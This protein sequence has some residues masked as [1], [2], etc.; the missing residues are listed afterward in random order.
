MN[1]IRDA[2]PKQAKTELAYG[3]RVMCSHVRVKYDQFAKLETG[4]AQATEAGHPQWL[5]NIY[6]LMA[7]W[8]RQSLNA[9]LVSPSPSA[10]PSPPAFPPRLGKTQKDNPFVHFRDN[11]PIDNAHSEEELGD[12]APIDNGPI[13]NA[14][15][16]VAR[17]M[18]GDRAIILLKNGDE[19]KSIGF[20]KKRNWIS[21]HHI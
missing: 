15:I 14:P 18:K 11:A 8:R 16:E 20:Q 7:D 10:S 2:D 1:R 21:A 19:I 4:Q 12:H 5:Q 6:A 3:Y 9:G 17:Y 13:D